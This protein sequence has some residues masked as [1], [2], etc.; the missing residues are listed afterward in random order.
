MKHFEIQVNDEVLNYMERLSFELEGMKKVVKEIITDA[1]DNPLV[2]DGEGFKKYDQ[3]YQERNAAYEVAKQHIQNAYIPATVQPKVAR[4][5]LN[6]STG[7]LMFDADV[8]EDTQL[9]VNDD[10][11]AFFSAQDDDA[12]DNHTCSTC[13]T[14]SK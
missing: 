6:Y 8:S 2:L 14:C 1:Q 4:W 5:D 3:R 13:S 11:L 7:L 10:A 12:C 9:T